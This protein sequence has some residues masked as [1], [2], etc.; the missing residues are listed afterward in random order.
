MSRQVEFCMNHATEAE[1][2]NHL[3]HCD[4]DFVPSLSGRVDIGGYA[5]KIAA[6]ATRFE[7]WVEG[8]LVGLMAAYCNDSERRVAFITSVSVL[9]GWQGR[10]IA[11]QMMERC[12]RYVK[13]LGFARIE[14]EVDNENLG[15][16]NLYEKMG[17]VINRACDR[18]VIMHLNIGKDV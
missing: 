7:A 12:I 2:A 10:S 1:I 8:V 14:L 6:K 18:T 4:A 9:H 17:F 16:A 13:E 15:A 5:H 3:S 11:S